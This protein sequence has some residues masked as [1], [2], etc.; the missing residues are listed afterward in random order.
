MNILP[1][2]KSHPFIHSSPIMRT[3]A[4]AGAVKKV[5]GAIKPLKFRL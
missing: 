4:G 5:G 2:L 1:A 3:L